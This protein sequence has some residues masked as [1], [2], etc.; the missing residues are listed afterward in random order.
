MERPI[1][2]GAIIGATL[3]LIFALGSLLGFGF[4]EGMYFTQNHPFYA[5]V[6]MSLSPIAGGFLAGMISRPNPRRA[7]MLAGLVGS[8]ILFILWLVFS[9]V[10]WQAV[11]SGLVVV[12]VWTFLAR[13]GA[14]LSSSR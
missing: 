1:L 4:S 13:F 9:G 2:L 8:M 3:M 14:R 6:I 7:G 10:S 5:L 12:F 11:V